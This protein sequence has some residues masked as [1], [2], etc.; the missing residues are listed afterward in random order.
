MTGSWGTQSAAMEEHFSNNLPNSLCRNLDSSRAQ[1]GPPV[2]ARESALSLQ[3]KWVVDLSLEMAHPCVGADVRR[4]ER[5]V[6]RTWKEE[7]V[8]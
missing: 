3:R 4:S 1:E 5:D 2:A 7:Q 8:D 6:L